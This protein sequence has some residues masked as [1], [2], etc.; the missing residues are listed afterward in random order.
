ME[1]IL[2]PIHQPSV[3]ALG[4]VSFLVYFFY[5]SSDL[6]IYFYL[7]LF[8]SFFTSA[9]MELVPLQILIRF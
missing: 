5:S 2:K 9:V 1:H 7:L 3:E 8:S 4:P 6:A